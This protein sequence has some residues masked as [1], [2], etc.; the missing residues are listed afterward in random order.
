MPKIPQSSISGFDRELKDQEIALLNSLNSP[1]R[2]QTF[3]DTVVY[4]A[5]ERNRSVIEVLRERQAHCLDGGMFAAACLR[6]IGFPPLILDLIPEPGTDDD[7]VLALYKVE[8]C[9]GA[10]AKSNYSGLRFREPVFRT[11]R[12]LVMSYFEDFFNTS[13]Q[14]TLRAY[15]RPFSLAKFDRFNWFFDSRGVDAVE[16]YLK[17]LPSIPVINATQISK[18]NILDKRSVDAGCLGLNPEGVFHG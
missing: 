3:L 7:H 17:T 18:L 11:L 6:R 2:I 1:F 12:E 13:A 15:T 4:P 5:G 9:W 10:V 16:K 8:G 14:K